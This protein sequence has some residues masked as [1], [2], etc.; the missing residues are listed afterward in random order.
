MTHTQGQ[1]AAISSEL[2]TLVEIAGR[3]GFAATDELAIGFVVEA[4]L[5]HRDAKVHYPALTASLSRAA[6]HPLTVEKIIAIV[7][8]RLAEMQ[9]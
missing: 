4:S 1:A 3:K 5:V 7:S 6:F 2:D 8:K 9:A